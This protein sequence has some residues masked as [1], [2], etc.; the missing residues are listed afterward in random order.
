MKANKNI[1]T[2]NRTK[3]KYSPIDQLRLHASERDLEF[4][5]Q[6][7]NYFTD[8]LCQ[9][10]L[11]FYPNVDRAYDILSQTININKENLTIAEGSDRILKNIFECFRISLGIGLRYL[12]IF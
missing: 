4:D 3:S 6:L 5:P 1:L 11:R 10:D 8:S 12:D 2:V 9:E 7:W